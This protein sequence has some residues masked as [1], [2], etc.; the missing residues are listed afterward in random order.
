M[1]IQV[2][3]GPDW[4][5]CFGLGGTVVYDFPQ[6]WSEHSQVETSDSFRTQEMLQQQIAP[7]AYRSL[8]QPIS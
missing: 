2:Q 5:F 6:P 1:Q 7:N 4:N 3:N 8:A